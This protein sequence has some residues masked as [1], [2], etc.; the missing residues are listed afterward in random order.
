MG[1]I[2]FWTHAVTFQKNYL[3]LEVVQNAMF[4]II[5][6]DLLLNLKYSKYVD[7]V[8]YNNPNINNN[9]ENLETVQNTMLPIINQDILLNLNI[10]QKQLGILGKTIFIN[11]MQYINNI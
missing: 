2:A 11:N 3:K 8:V 6:Q 7:M 4:P 9:D 1:S 5:N 10:R